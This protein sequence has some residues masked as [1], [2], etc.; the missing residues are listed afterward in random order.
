MEEEERL[1]YMK[2]DGG[3][4]LLATLSWK[5]APV[6]KDGISNTGKPVHRIRPR[7]GTFAKRIPPPSSFA[8]F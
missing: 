5:G 2:K 3:R 6:S 8:E 7:K 1:V 4:I